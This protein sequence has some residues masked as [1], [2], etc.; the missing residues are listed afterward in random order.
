M[1]NDSVKPSTGAQARAPS[2]WLFPRSTSEALIRT[3]WGCWLTLLAVVSIMVLIKGADRSVVRYYHAASAAWWAGQDLYSG[4]VDSFN[5]L[6]AFAVLFTPFHLMGPELA[7]LLWRWLSFAALT[8]GFW[9]LARLVAPDKAPL[10]M[11]IM[12]VLAIPGAA[13]MIRNGQA[14]TIMTALMIHAAAD[15]AEERWNRASFWLGLALALKPLA[16]VLM[17]LSGTLYRPMFWRLILAVAAVLLIPFLAAGPGYVVAQYRAMGAQYGIAYGA[18]LGPW[19]EFGM[20]MVKFGLPLPP[21]AMT[22][23]RL[24]AALATLGLAWAARKRHAARLAA[25]YVL[26]LSVCYLMLF[27]PANEENTY[28]A[29]AG[30]VAVSAAVTLVRRRPVWI[31]ACLVVLCFAFGSDGYGTLVFQATKLWFKPL[32]CIVF[33]GFLLPGLWAREDRA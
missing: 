5:Y 26:A 23:L 28:G 21:A 9:R 24:A 4:Q 6:P 29:L 15:M 3:G 13:G 14:T 2:N 10:V 17:L 8:A 11:G 30:I 12:L 16:I 19:S 18:A 20:M 31:A 25:F 32:A 27:N 1:P 33:L 22:A 7:G